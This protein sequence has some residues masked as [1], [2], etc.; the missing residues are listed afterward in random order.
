PFAAVLGRSFG[1]ELLERASALPA[2]ELDAA[3]AALERAGILR[4]GAEGDRYDFVH[5]LVRNAAYR[6]LSLP[7]RKLVHLH[8]ARA[9]GAMPEAEGALAGDLAH[10]A[11]LGGDL[12]RAARACV[13]AGERALALFAVEESRELAARGL[14]FVV[15]LPPATRLPIEMKLLSIQVRARWS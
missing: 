13:A 4:A 6:S 8:I 11:A 15:D 3:V 2:A 9:I 7:R 10:H 14:R 5:D 12:E 1:P